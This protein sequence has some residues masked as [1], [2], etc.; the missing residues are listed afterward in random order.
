MV[1]IQ[2]I[3]PYQPVKLPYKRVYMFVREALNLYLV[4]WTCQSQPQPVCPGL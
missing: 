4:V 2:V 1:I 3:L